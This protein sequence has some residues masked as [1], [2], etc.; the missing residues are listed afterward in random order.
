MIPEASAENKKE[1][2]LSAFN[3]YSPKSERNAKISLISDREVKEEKWR[4]RR[5]AGATAER[6]LSDGQT[7]KDVPSSPEDKC[8]RCTRSAPRKQ[9]AAVRPGDAT[10]T[11]VWGRHELP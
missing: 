5:R 7:P 9:V 6:R 2:H 11:A 4:K 8:V 10:A 3:R 1:N